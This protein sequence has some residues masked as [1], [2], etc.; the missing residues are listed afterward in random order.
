[1]GFPQREIC[2]RGVPRLTTNLRFGDL[3]LLQSGL[4]L[5]FFTNF[6]EMS[7]HFMLEHGSK[8]T[9]K[10]V[11]KIPTVRGADIMRDPK[12]TKVCMHALVIFFNLR[13]VCQL[14]T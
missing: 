13:A 11:R 2:S 9:E 10:K 6:T 4:K 12:V 8:Y 1:M 14:F 3:Q 5:I 7:E